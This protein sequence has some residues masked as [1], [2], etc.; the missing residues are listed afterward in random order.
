[1]RPAAGREGD[2]SRPK[3]VISAV[4]LAFG[5]L[6]VQTVLF[7]F[8][9]VTG[10]FSALAIHPEVA[11]ILAL[12]SVGFTVLEAFLIY[13]A[14]CGRNGAR[15]L[16]IGLILFSIVSVLTTTAWAEGFAKQ[17]LWTG[18]SILTMCLYLIAEWCFW[19]YP[20]QTPGFARCGQ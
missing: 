8:N 2:L 14:W 15:I 19:S 5:L 3:T 20:S 11:V 16:Y 4:Y 13:G 18:L 10:Q 9:L 1:M 7:V 6:A 17:P 12:V